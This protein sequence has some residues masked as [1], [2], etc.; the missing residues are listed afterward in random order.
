[1]DCDSLRM[2]MAAYRN[3]PATQNTDII[4]RSRYTSEDLRLE[5]TR[6]IVDRSAEQLL[7]LTIPIWDIQ[8][9]LTHVRRFKSLEHVRFLEFEK[10]SLGNLS[11]LAYEDALKLLPQN[12]PKLLKDEAYALM[13]MFVRE[14]SAVFNNLL[15][16]IE[17]Y[18][19]K[20][21]K[22]ITR[23]VSDMQLVELTRLL[24]PLTSPSNLNEFS[25]LH[26]LGQADKTNVGVLESIRVFPNPDNDVWSQIKS[27]EEP[28]LQKCRRLKE[29]E[30][31]HLPPNSF[32]WA[33]R[34]RKQWLE[35]VE[36]NRG[37]DSIHGQ[38]D[39][40]PMAPTKSILPSTL[41]PLKS[42]IFLSPSLTC[43]HVFDDI[44]FAFSDTLKE[45]RFKYKAK[46]GRQQRLTKH[47]DAPLFIGRQIYSQLSRLQHLVIQS[48]GVCCIWLRPEALDRSPLIELDI[49]NSQASTLK[50][51][52]TTPC[53]WIKPIELEQ[54]Q[55][56]RL[57]GPPSATFNPNTFHI[58]EEGLDILELEGA[59]SISM[60][61]WRV[62][63]RDFAPNI[64]FIFAPECIRDNLKEW[65]EMTRE[66]TR[67]QWVKA[68]SL[69]PLDQETGFTTAEIQGQ[70]RLNMTSEHISYSFRARDYRVKRQVR[71][72][73]QEETSD[74]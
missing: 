37:T 46:P 24:P 54:L 28:F 57:L 5:L 20:K 61:A 22:T 14:H 3:N 9:Y 11:R 40:S 10:V 6:E 34:E 43:D 74:I 39:H 51:A 48:P 59:W 70:R 26:F 13:T 41:V 12:L 73:R 58:V 60:A 19:S 47:V 16:S 36:S 1:M 4:F 52:F 71:Q 31:W 65:I 8:W 62:L 17:C 15:R 18:F 38:A 53:S 72:E 29:L 67:L 66:M 32:E 56:L 50:T 45:L 2:V 44:L 69:S 42:I 30:W 55:V 23:N 64:S 68:N 63:L 35:R 33:V 21:G 7:S 49:D 27:L 25:T